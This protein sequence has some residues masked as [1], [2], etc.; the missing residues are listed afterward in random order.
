MNNVDLVQNQTANDELIGNE[1]QGNLKND[2]LV[3]VYQQNN[4]LQVMV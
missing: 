3:G 4:T 2:H 1:G